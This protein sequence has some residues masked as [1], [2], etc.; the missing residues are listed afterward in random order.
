M[1]RRGLVGGLLVIVC[2]AI[3]WGV[4]SQGNQLA[5]LRAEQ[6]QLLAQMAAKADGSASPGAAEAAGAG[7]ETPQPRLVA[8][9]ELLRLRS[10]VTRLTERRNELA[11]ARAENER[12]RAENTKLRTQIEAPPAGFLTPEKTDALAKA[13]E[14]AESIACVNNLKQLWVAARTWAIDNGN[15]SPPDMLSMTNEMGTPKIL[16]C[17]GDKTREPAKDW[18]SYTAAH[19]SYEYLAPSAPDTEPTRV[20]FRCPIHGHVGL[21]DGSVQGEI[22]KRHPE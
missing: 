4:W 9:P 5:S 17:P 8:T 2:L 18:A 14:K 22:A 13:K 6:R 15:I 21:C 7:S 19:C 12:L 16:V 20:L 10:E 3:L 1:N 11:G